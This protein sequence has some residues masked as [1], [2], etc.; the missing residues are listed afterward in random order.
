MDRIRE[1]IE[2]RAQENMSTPVGVALGTPIGGAQPPSRAPPAEG[3]DVP[4]DS[5]E[6]YKQRLKGA[7]LVMNCMTHALDGNYCMFGVFALYDDDVFVKTL[8]LVLKLAMPVPLSTS[9]VV[10]C[11]LCC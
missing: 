6:L 5:K 2:I 11:K 3:Q 4:A 8:S 7:A 10:A 9:L 1:T